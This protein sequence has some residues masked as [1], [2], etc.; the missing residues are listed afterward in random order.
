MKRLLLPL[1]AALA[2][3]TAVNAETFYLKCTI[4]KGRG[5]PDKPFK[6]FADPTVDNHQF[7]LNEDN[8][9]AVY[10]LAENNTSIK[11]DNVNF[12]QESID[13]KY[14]KGTGYSEKVNNI[15]INRLTGE[16]VQET[17]LGF[18]LMRLEGQCKKSEPKKT[19]F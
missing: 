13:M 19:L 15:S 8:Q 2:L 18:Q 16:I 6:T 5:N 14:T 10:F 7:T 12:N 1:L 4:T 17:D 11:I 3:P 9:S